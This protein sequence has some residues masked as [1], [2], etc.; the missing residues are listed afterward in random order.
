MAPL[1]KIPLLFSDAIGMRITGKPPNLPL[2]LEE[3]VV[4]D[5]RERFLK[6][7]AWP[8]VFLRVRSFVETPVA[9]V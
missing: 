5:W 4:P 9:N 3:H 1:L 8:C 2:P 6:S 7:L